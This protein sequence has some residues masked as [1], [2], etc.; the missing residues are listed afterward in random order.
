MSDY[1]QVVKLLE[2]NTGARRL[3]NVFDDFVE[4]FALSLRNAVDRQGWQEREDRYLT[5]AGQYTSEQ[6]ARFADAFARV[7]ALMEQEPRDVLGHLYMSLEL[8]NEA[9][10]QFYTPY[11][12]ARVMADMQSD[13]LTGAIERDGF[14]TLY[15]P[16]CGAGAFLVAAAESLR[17]KGFNPQQ[18]LH[19]T[20]EDLSAQAVHMV[21]IHLTLL[22]I[23][24]VVYRRNTLTMET[25]DTWH[26]PA[27]ILGDWSRKLRFADGINGA[28]EL[29]QA[30]PEIEQVEQVGWD[31]V[32]AEVT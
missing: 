21:Y 25:F 28:Q 11:D 8:G 16:A 17:V 4:M 27:H 22:H 26:T 24:A 23:P 20:C 6:L 15:E 10:G 5:V 31:D 29:F 3:S 2:Q 1:K 19:V 12:I 7:V 30:M 13:T 32:F 14:A 9:M 18:Q